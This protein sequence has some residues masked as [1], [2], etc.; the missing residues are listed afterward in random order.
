L[1]VSEKSEGITDDWIN[2]SYEIEVEGANPH[3]CLKAPYDP[4]WEKLKT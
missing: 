3:R 4:K 1:N 2:G